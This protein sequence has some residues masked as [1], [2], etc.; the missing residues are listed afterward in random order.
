MTDLSSLAR[1]TAS[2]LLFALALGACTVG[3]D[4]AAPSLEAPTDWHSWRSGNA[5]LHD[6]ATDGEALPADWW[7]LWGDPVLNDLEARALAANPDIASAALHFAAARVQ[8]GGA[9]AAGLPQ[10]NLSGS[11]TRQRLS[12]NGASTRLFDV[13]GSEAERDQMARFLA[14]PFTLFQ[15]GFDAGWEPDLWGKVRRSLEVADARVEGQAATLEQTR[16]AVASEVARSYVELRSVQR[17]LAL[18]QEDRD[19]LTEREEI[20][21]ARVQAGLDGHTVL[22]GETMARAGAQA[23]LAPLRAQEAALINALAVLTEER[24][25]GLQDLLDPPA[26]TGAPIDPDLGLGLPSEVALGRPD[27][28]AAA[29]QLHAATAEIGV[30][31]ADLYP[32]IRLGGGFNLESYRSESLFDWGSRTWSVGPSLNLPLFDGG[33]RRSVVALRRIEQREAAVRFQQTVLSAWQEIDDALNGYGAERS[34]RDELAARLA[35]AER[36]RDL[37]QANYAAGNVSYLPLLD[38]RRAVLGAQRELV[39]SEGDL[40]TRFIAVNKAVGN[41]PPG[42]PAGGEAAP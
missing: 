39:Q 25:G 9:E 7:T 34:R 40:R 33:R 1:T 22:E 19:I 35:G 5:A 24:P 2:P 38:A 36:R 10:V 31:V 3:P 21:G 18:A 28:R 23:T 8:R 17:Q 30:A 26:A 37:V 16:L 32:S 27:V 11:V 15:G 4:Y 13:I 12:E 42:D 41:V 6:V 29:A 20:V 14:N